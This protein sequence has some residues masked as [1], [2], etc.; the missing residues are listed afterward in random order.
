[1]LKIDERCAN[2]A[3]KLRVRGVRV[4]PAVHVVYLQGLPVNAESATTDEQLPLFFAPSL[5]PPF[6]YLEA[7]TS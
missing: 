2:T 5:I 4:H 7:L 6:T 3:T 1:M